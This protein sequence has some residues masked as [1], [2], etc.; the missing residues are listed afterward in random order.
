MSEQENLVELNLEDSDGSIENEEGQGGNDNSW[1]NSKKNPSNF[2]KLYKKAK[3]LEKEKKDL[4]AKL[5]AMANDEWEEKPNKETKTDSSL[6][7]KIF[8]LENPEA[9]WL[10]NEIKTVAS[11]HNMDLDTAWKFLKATKPKESVS[12]NDFSI[13]GKKTAD[14]D[15]KSISIEET[16]NLSAEERRAW[17][18]ANG[19]SI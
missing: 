16:A 10:L 19:W 9:K 12:T 7:L 13:K 18:K 4:E 3:E 1:E 6:E 11:E 14:I 17:R 15:Y 2:K 5:A 8:W